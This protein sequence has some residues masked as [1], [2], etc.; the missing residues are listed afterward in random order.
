MFDNIKY[1][2]IISLTVLIGYLYFNNT[3]LEKEVDTLTMDKKLL[4]ENVKNK[5]NEIKRIKEEVKQISLIKDE[6]NK[7][8]IEQQQKIDTLNSK[9]QKHNLQ[10]ISYKKPV[11]VQK[12]INKGTFNEFRC[13]ENITKGMKDECK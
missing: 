1:I 7:L 4:S 13:L 3:S 10:K 12:I 5:D 9:I 11:L 8:S 6:V 2:L